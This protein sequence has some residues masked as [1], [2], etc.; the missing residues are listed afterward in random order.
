MRGQPREQWAR[1]VPG[2]AK[3]VGGN[4]G[5]DCDAGK[6]KTA[7]FMTGIRDAICFSLSLFP[8][9]Q[10]VC[11]R[12]ESARVRVRESRREIW[13]Q[14]LSGYS[15]ELRPFLSR[16]VCSRGGNSREY[17]ERKPMLKVSETRDQGDWDPGT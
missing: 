14:R 3:S 17:R 1:V 6:R 5:L 9:M 15:C 11:S 13:G 16:S 12:C 2:S 7:L 10:R 8:V 4:E